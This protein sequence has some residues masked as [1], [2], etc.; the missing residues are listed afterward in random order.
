[1]VVRLAADLALFADQRDLRETKIHHLDDVGAD[2]R[3]DL[4]Q[5]VMLAVLRLVDGGFTVGLD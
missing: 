4:R 1:M 5:R 3:V 2:Q